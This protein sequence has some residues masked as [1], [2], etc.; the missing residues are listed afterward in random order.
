MRESGILFSRREKRI[1]F[2]LHAT[3]YFLLVFFANFPL[4]TS[5]PHYEHSFAKK[6][7]MV[8]ESVNQSPPV[9]TVSASSADLV[10]SKRK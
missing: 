3:H 4:R 7:S 6:C 1:L 8:R 2:S 9:L 5:I 10:C